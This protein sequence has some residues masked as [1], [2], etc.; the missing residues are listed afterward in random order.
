MADS[1]TE[2]LLE[3]LLNGEVP[4]ITPRSRNEELLLA[5]CQK[6]AD[7]PSGGVTPTGAVKIAEYTVDADGATATSFEFT[8]AEYPELAQYNTLKGVY[9]K[10][11]NGSM[12]WVA[13]MLNG[14]EVSKLATTSY[15]MATFQVKK[16]GNFFTCYIGGAFNPSVY[17]FAISTQSTSSFTRNFAPVEISDLTSIAIESYTPFLDEGGT[18]EI[19]GWNE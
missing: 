18:I 12:P 15:S 8:I 7:L 6:A 13:L 11:A 14:T 1:R 3:A 5:L 2:A 17:P 16:V 9:K 10:T 19:W 4:D